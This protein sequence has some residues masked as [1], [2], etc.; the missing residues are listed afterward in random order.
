[1]FAGGK[2]SRMRKHLEQMSNPVFGGYIWQPTFNDC[3]EAAKQEKS[4]E[5]VPEINAG[6]YHNENI[7][8]SQ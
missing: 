2:T 1:L 4:I 6:A 8:K 7:T 3:R 5:Q